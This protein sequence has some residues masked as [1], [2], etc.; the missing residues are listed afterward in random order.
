MF[1][2]IL[3]A[4][5]IS[6]HSLA[7]E[8]GD[9]LAKASLHLGPVSTVDTPTFIVRRRAVGYGPDENSDTHRV[10]SCCVHV[11]GCAHSSEQARA[12]SSP[13]QLPAA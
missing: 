10:A 13:S 11:S 7:T 9:G 3:E 5:G 6:H 2:K 4:K 12:L 1:S 8:Q